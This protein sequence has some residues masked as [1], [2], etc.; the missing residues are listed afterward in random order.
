[1]KKKEEIL[2]ALEENRKAYEELERISGQNDD[3]GYDLLIFQ[4][5]VEAL[6]WVLKDMKKC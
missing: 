4:G 5:W 2:E 3:A 6:E 1:M